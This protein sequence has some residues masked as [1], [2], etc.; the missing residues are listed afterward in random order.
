[1]LK[2]PKCQTTEM[3]PCTANDSEVE[4]DQCSQCGGIWFDGGELEKLLGNLAHKK[5]KPYGKTELSSRTCPRCQKAMVTFFYPHTY[6][7][8]QMCEKCR[9]IWLDEREYDEI[10]QVRKKL[11][12]SGE[13]D[14]PSDP[15]GIKGI[16]AS[17]SSTLPRSIHSSSSFELFCAAALR[18]FKLITDNPKLTTKNYFFIFSSACLAS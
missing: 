1:M 9:G 5:L 14:K 4:V 13:L 7:K 6:A 18:G 16:K 17:T 2:C 8:I 11:K 10:Y 15:D 12:L 3:I